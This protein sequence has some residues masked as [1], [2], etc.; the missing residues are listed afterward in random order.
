MVCT[1]YHLVSRV[2]TQQTALSSLAVSY[3]FRPIVLNWFD[4]KTGLFLPLSWLQLFQYSIITNINSLIVTLIN[5][6]S[7]I[8]IRFASLNCNARIANDSHC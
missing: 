4:M 5:Y 2:A 6:E 3:L 7:C 1:N 8:M